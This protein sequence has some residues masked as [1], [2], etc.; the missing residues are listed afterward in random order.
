MVNPPGQDGRFFN[1][2]LVHEVCID[3]FWLGK[4]EVVNEQF[5]RFRPGHDSKGYEG[6]SLNGGTQPVVCVRW[7][8]AFAFAEWLG[9]SSG[10]RYDFR[11]PT[12]AEWEYSCR[13]S[14]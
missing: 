1:E 6:H 12:K 3:G 13:A 9:K 11:F 2:G 7:E 5:R 8:D 14:K 10:G 4:Y